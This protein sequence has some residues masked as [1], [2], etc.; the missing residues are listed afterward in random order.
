M[1]EEREKLEKNEQFK[2]N[3][4][5]FEKIIEEFRYTHILP[6]RSQDDNVDQ[7]YPAKR[8]QLQRQN[9]KKSQTDADQNTDPSIQ[10]VHH[11]K[12][13]RKTNRS[14][15]P[16]EHYAH[17]PAGVPD[18]LGKNLIVMFIGLN[19][20]IATVKAGHAFAGP[21]NLFWKLLHSSQIVC[22]ETRLRPE[23]DVTLQKWD[24]G[25]TNLVF[26]SNNSRIHIY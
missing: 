24:V 25:I 22:T 8:S 11:N 10:M 26:S 17:L 5:N 7:C 20:G 12:R 1:S 21:T 3:K 18:V 13:K 15:V 4:T 16:P 9:I 2:G 19:P 14:Y 23:D 6:K